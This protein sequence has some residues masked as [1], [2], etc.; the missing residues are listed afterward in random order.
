MN[1][2]RNIEYAF[3]GEFHVTV[4]TSKHMHMKSK[5]MNSKLLKITLIILFFLSNNLIYAQN[6]SVLISDSGL[7]KWVEYLVI[8]V[9]ILILLGVFAVLASVFFMLTNVQFT[10]FDMKKRGAYGEVGE[11]NLVSDKTESWW[12]KVTDVIQG[13]VPIDHEED[14]LLDHDYDGI[15]E[16]DNKL[17]PWWLWIFYL[18]ILYAIIYMGIYHFGGNGLSSGEK[19]IRQMEIAQAQVDEYKANQVVTVDEANLIA[20]TD[21]ADLA[22]G[23]KIYKANCVACHGALGEG[24]IGP[25]MTD[26]YWIHG[27]DIKDL[28]R[29]I[30]DGVIDKGMQSWAA[31][32]PADQMHQVASYMLTL[33]GTN[34]PNQKEAQGE[35]YVRVVEETE[36]PAE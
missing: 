15:H 26:Q 6:T 19:Y 33:E 28:Y 34:P 11:G 22:A 13:A 21:E 12:S 5:F 31:L 23:E 17:P 10:L 16:L 35:L 9:A 27:G 2:A 14:V 3:C 8:V 25:N 32:L 1:N 30:K 36:T 20:L 4:K 29:T 24:G 18:S 7:P